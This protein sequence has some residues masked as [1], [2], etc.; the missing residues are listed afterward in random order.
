M[1]ILQYCL[2]NRILEKKLE[3]CRTKMFRIAFSW[4]HD[5]MLADDLVQ[6]A[7]TKALLRLNQLKKPDVLESWVI[8][9]L[10]NVWKD[11][12]RQQKEF[13]DIDEYI[14]FSND[15]PE[16][17]HES[18]RTTYQVREAIGLLP[19]G[20]RQVIS[21]IDLE[22]FSY[23]EVSQVLEIPVGTVMSRLNRARKSMMDKL[24]NENYNENR[25]V[26]LHKRQKAGEI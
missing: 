3:R 23:N 5:Q 24:S 6:D 17:I 10:N 15:C 14:H 4:S 21:L 7:M 18:E 19:M 1:S 11:Y 20:Q 22:G 25:V 2:R 8:S 12:L 13:V 9:I 26:F 16:N